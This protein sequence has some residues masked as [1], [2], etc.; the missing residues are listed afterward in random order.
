LGLPKHQSKYIFILAVNLYF[1]V[2]SATRLLSGELIDYQETMWNEKDEQAM[3][4]IFL[5]AGN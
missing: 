2:F 4:F 3:Q 5:Q 1:S